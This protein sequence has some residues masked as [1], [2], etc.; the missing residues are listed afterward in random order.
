MLGA[1]AAAGEFD[2]RW[3]ECV[4][5]PIARAG[6]DRQADD[7]ATLRGNQ[8]RPGQSPSR[9]QH[10]GCITIDQATTNISRTALLRL[11]DDAWVVNTGRARGR[12]AEAVNGVAGCA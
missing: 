3:D 10:N 4:G 7:P 1:A 12:I 8:E 2:C 11:V 9:V 5:R 6:Q